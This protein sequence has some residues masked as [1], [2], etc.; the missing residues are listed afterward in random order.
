MNFKE[1][2]SEI[3]DNFRMAR[4]FDESIFEISNTRVKVWWK[5]LVVMTQKIMQK[6]PFSYSNAACYDCFCFKKIEG[7]MKN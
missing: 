1:L 4:I 2:V 6:Y 3:F 5:V 7:Y